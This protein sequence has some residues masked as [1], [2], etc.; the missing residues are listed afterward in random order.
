VTKGATLS[1]QIA[2]CQH[3][4]VTAPSQNIGRLTITDKNSPPGRVVP[5]PDLTRG[6]MILDPA[7]HSKPLCLLISMEHYGGIESSAEV[8]I[9]W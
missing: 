6:G 3:V 8:D 2:P 9:G 4:K 7:R 5:Y 1:K